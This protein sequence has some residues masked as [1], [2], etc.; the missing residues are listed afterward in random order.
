MSG[1]G[2]A[3]VWRTLSQE[4]MARLVPHLVSELQRAGFDISTEQMLSIMDLASSAYKNEPLQQQMAARL[5]MYSQSSSA[6]SSTS[7]A[8]PKSKKTSSGSKPQCQATIKSKNNEHRQCSKPA[9]EGSVY[10]AQHLKVMANDAQPQISKDSFMNAPPLTRQKAAQN[11]IKPHPESSGLM[12]DSEGYVSNGDAVVARREND[13]DRELTDEEKTY[14]QER[15]QKVATQNTPL[16]P[17]QPP[18]TNSNFKPLKLGGVAGLRMANGQT[19]GV[20]RHP[21]GISLPKTQKPVVEEAD[22]DD[23]EEKD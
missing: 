23:E 19:A 17:V 12:V 10:C 13:T 6:S 18:T 21:A 22:D 9:R 2:F 14:V 1:S 3:D 4:C 15:G 8:K 16:K 5:N 7:A 20:S 11:G